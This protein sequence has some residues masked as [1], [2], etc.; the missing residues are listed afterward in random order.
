[1]GKGTG[2]G[3]A[4]VYGIVRQHE[5]WIEVISEVGRG[6]TFA[7]YLP[8]S[9]DDA[10]PAPVADPSRTRLGG[11]ETILVVEDDSAVRFMIESLLIRSGYRVLVAENGLEALGRWMEHSAEIAL[12][13]TDLVMPDNFSGRELAEHIVRQ[14]PAVRILY[15]SGYSSEF[16]GKDFPLRA[17][18]NFLSK[19][20][21]A[22]VLLRA[23]R[24]SLDAGAT[25]SQPVPPKPGP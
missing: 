13:L 18:E 9:L 14:K 4:T 19:P 16:A 24:A 17:G 15:M 2:L 11:T 5:G 25:P 7:V 23:V 1:V 3:L 6:S 8:L 20:F 22:A 12:L 10:S 21:D